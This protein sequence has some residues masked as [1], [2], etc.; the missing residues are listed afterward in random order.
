[1]P[2]HCAPSVCALEMNPQFQ[3][4]IPG[5]TNTDDAAQAQAALPLG[6]KD[7]QSR[8]HIARRAMP[9]LRLTGPECRV[10]MLRRRLAGRW[11]S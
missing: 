5:E 2:V 11:F 7:D 1:M 3:T 10:P 4:I 6:K 8:V 9:A